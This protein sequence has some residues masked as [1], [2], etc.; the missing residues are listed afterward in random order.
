M[1][2]WFTIEQLDN[3]TYAISEY[4]HWE[5]P[6]CYLLCGTESAIL[7]DT[8]LGVTNIREVVEGITNLPILVLTT[9]AHWDHIG[10][11]KYFEEIAVHEAE[12]SWLEEKFP[13]SQEVVKRNLM[14]GSKCDAENHGMGGIC[15]LPE[16]FCVEKYKIFQGPVHRVLHDGDSIDLGNRQ[17]RVIH[18][19]GHSPGHCCF[20]EEARGYLFSGDLIYKGCL[21]AFYL[22]TDPVAFWKSVQKVCELDISRVFPGH[23]DLDV[24]VRMVSQIEDAF[25]ELDRQ[26]KLKQGTGL[27][28]F[29]EFQI[30]L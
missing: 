22:T 10:S 7:I 5:E 1:N 6:H 2:N 24:Q 16:T 25:A 20:F 28:E 26:G 9:H 17:L 19:P 23:H 11:H 13:L 4:E 21:D 15:L 27:Y 18:T 14:C 29:E 12:K 3:D 8:G 30:H